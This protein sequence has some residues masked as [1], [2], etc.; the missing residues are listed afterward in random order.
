MLGVV[1]GPGLNLPTARLSN[2]CVAAGHAA[3][4]AVPQ[5]NVR[6]AISR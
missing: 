2:A 3:S 1:R 5:A 6:R 4:G